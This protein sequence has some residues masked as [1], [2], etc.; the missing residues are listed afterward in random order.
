M[1]TKKEIKTGCGFLIL[2][3]MVFVLA[4]LGGWQLAAVYLG[5]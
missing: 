2:V 3:G 5:L 4:V 1:L